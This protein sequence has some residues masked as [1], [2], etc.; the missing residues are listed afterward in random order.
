M[1]MLNLVIN[2]A[3][4]CCHGGD[5]GLAISCAG[6][7]KKLCGCFC[8]FTLFGIGNSDPRCSMYQWNFEVP[9]KGGRWHSP[10]PN[11]QYIPL[12]YHLYIAF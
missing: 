12:I 6:G 9:V 5:S 7:L 3:G 10:S 4:F 2:L 1:G 11:W 8:G